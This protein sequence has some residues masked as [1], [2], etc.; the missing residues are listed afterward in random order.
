MSV[1]TP[2]SK[3][4]FLLLFLCLLMTPLQIGGK[5]DNGLVSGSLFEETVEMRLNGRPHDARALRMHRPPFVPVY[6]IPLR[7]HLGRSGRNP[8][9]FKEILEEINRIWWSQAGICF[10]MRAVIHDRVF[11]EGMDVWFLPQIDG[12]DLWNGYY[13]GDHEIRV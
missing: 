10:E 6:R 3:V 2:A 5:V 11:D 1:S 13:R 8:E 7:V 4:I 12:G 9:Q